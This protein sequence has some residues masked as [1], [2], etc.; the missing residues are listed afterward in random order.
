MIKNMKFEFIISKW[1][2]FY[3]FI[4]NLSEWHFSCRTFY[5]EF[6]RKE[7]GGFSKKEKK[8]LKLFAKLHEKYPFGSDFFGQI[9]FV[10]KNP[11]INLKRERP[12]KDFQLLKEIFKIF[13]P[14]FEKLYKKELPL[15][16]IWEKNL[17]EYSNKILIVRQLNTNLAFLYHTKPIQK[18]IKVYLLFSSPNLSGGGTNMDGESITLEI[19]RYPLKA[20]NQVIGIIWHE[21]IHL[22]FENDYFL[23][24]I[25]ETFAS[26]QKK[27]SL[28]K[29]AA[30]SSLL[31]N[32]V[33]G[34]NLL[35]IKSKL[36]NSKIPSKYNRPFLRL[37]KEYL[38]KKKFFDKQYIRNAVSIILS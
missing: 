35:K 19:S 33:L 5:N 11:L 37:S 24:L 18:N 15:L 32:G 30:A 20:I 12:K 34:V 28:L 10:K 7:L 23:P 36:L 1:A 31:P 29:E 16:K 6:W 2:N 8:S 13:V 9:F 26:D 27:I 14:N 4:S 17:K 38:R 21:L 25:N 3:F 22:Y